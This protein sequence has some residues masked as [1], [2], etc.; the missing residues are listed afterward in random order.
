[1][2]AK[3]EEKLLK[4]MVDALQG[5]EIKWLCNDG[6]WNGMPYEHVEPVIRALDAY[7]KEYGIRLDRG[8]GDERDGNPQT[9]PR[10]TK[11]VKVG[12]PCA[13]CLSESLRK[14]S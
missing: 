4:Q 3:I 7:E 14:W 11:P 8:Q 9:C 6:H 12:V 10:C 2:E 5:V 1:M 13:I